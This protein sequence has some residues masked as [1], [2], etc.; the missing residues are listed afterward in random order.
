MYVYS[1]VLSVSKEMGLRDGVKDEG[2]EMED[3]ENYE[4]K[5]VLV[6]F[7]IARAKV[8]KRGNFGRYILGKIEG[9]GLLFNGRSYLEELE[10]NVV[11]KWRS[12]YCLEESVGMFKK[13]VLEEYGKRLEEKFNE[14]RM[15]R[16]SFLKL[17]K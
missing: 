1:L 14:L 10:L 7:D 11:R 17:C 13:L 3:W 16:E 12:V 15:E 2:L 4:V 5:G 6:Y 9:N 8:V